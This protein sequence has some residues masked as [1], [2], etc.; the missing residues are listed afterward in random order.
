MRG[1][2]LPY[3]K[4]CHRIASSTQVRPSQLKTLCCHFGVAA[5]FQFW[6]NNSSNFFLLGSYQNEFMFR[7]YNRTGHSSSRGG[8][9]CFRPF[10]FG[11]EE[12]W[13][14]TKLQRCPL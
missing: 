9:H 10:L 7:R 4:I 14:P 12:G 2:W 5:K 11:T 1:K 13:L 3:G 6:G 8:G